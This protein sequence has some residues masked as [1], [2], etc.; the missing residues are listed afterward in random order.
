VLLMKKVSLEAC[1]LLQKP[2]LYLKTNIHSFPGLPKVRHYCSVL[3]L[4]FPKQR[5]IQFIKSDSK[6]IYNFTEDLYFKI[7]DILLNFLFIKKS[8]KKVSQ[9]AQKYKA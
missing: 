8:L 5:H 3:T 1:I 6:D 2:W 9:F 7:N 4:F